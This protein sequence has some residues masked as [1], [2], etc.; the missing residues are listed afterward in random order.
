[1]LANLKINKTTE[2]HRYSINTVSQICGEQLL[3]HFE[4]E[5]APRARNPDASVCGGPQ[6]VSQMGAS[7]G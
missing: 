1:M 3:A 5:T 7:Q 6:E 2:F 4:E